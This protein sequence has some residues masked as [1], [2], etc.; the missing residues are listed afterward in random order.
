MLGCE[1]VGTL[2][3]PSE[4][5]SPVARTHAQRTL[6]K[7]FGASGALDQRRKSY[8]FTNKTPYHSI[9]GASW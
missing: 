9:F 3:S 4:I 1:G 2:G 6:A 5:V 7:A 8:F